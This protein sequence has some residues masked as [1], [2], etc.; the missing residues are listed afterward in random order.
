M[1]RFSEKAIAAALFA[2]MLLGGCA[3]QK[4][5]EQSSGTSGASQALSEADTT[6]ALSDELPEL[7]YDGAPCRVMIYDSSEQ[8]Y[9]MMTEGKETGDILNDA[10][11]QRNAARVRYTI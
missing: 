10:V 9:D 2:A 6:T 11:Y 7:H 4:D 8:N 3:A 1:K 5:A